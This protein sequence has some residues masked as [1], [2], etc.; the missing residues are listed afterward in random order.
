[1][2]WVDI[3]KNQITQGKEGILTSDSP[4]PKKKKPD[5]NKCRNILR[6]WN[7]NELKIK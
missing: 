7:A 1:M 4:L 3:L 6:K 2:S 5:D